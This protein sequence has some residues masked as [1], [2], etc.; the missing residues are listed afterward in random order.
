MG[1]CADL[2]DGAFIVSLKASKSNGSGATDLGAAG[3]DGPLRNVSSS[4][5]KSRL[6]GVGVWVLFS[7][8]GGRANG[9]GCGESSSPS[10]FDELLF[11]GGID[12]EPRLSQNDPFASN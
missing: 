12:D 4:S 7:A 5:H 8:E 11:F 3:F 10:P 6:G 2:D 1:F 9:M